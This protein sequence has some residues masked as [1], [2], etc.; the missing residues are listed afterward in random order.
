MMERAEPESF[1][2][3]EHHERARELSDRELVEE[4][5]RKDRKAT[6]EFVARCADHV[7]GYV[8]RRL[9]PRSDLVEDLVQEIFLAAWQSLHTFRGDSSL[10]SWL[11]GIARHKVE[12]HYRR[13]LRELQTGDEDEIPGDEPASST[14]LEE[15]LAARQ[16]G[17]RTREILAGLPEVYSLILSWRYWEKRSLREIAQQ[18]NKTEKAVERL[19]ARARQQFKKR[20]NEQ[21]STARR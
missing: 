1:V 18:T 19:L 3:Q 16:A 15:A 5:L 2:R 6:A 8:W 20:W 11:L 17:Q 14:D 7:Y 13:R 4:V 21:Q 9:V 12:D 10:R